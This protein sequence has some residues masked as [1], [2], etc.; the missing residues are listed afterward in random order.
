MKMI[1]IK[2]IKKTSDEAFELACDG[3]NTS[4]EEVRIEITDLNTTIGK[5]QKKCYRYKSYRSKSM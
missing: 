4:S 1:K 5:K 3:E 2:N